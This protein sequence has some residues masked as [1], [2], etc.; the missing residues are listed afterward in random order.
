MLSIYYSSHAFWMRD[1]FEHRRWPPL[2]SDDLDSWD[3][4]A[5]QEFCKHFWDFVA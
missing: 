5:L 3:I 4:E 1:A 2:E